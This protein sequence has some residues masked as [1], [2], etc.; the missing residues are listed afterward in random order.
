METTKIP[1]L[2]GAPHRINSLTSAS[3]YFLTDGIHNPDA[4][5]TRIRAYFVNLL[6]NCEPQRFRAAVLDAI[7]ELSRAIQSGSTLYV[8]IYGTKRTL[9]AANL[10]ASDRL[11]HHIKL[12]LTARELTAGLLT[13]PRIFLYQVDTDRY[14][15]TDK[16]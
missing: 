4:T 10:I 11:A 6:C 12:V 1:M 14:P 13:I 15:F 3:R 7:E 8:V 2:P 16:L 5:T 9:F